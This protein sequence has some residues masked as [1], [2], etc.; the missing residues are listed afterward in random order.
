[1]LNIKSFLIKIMEY[2]NKKILEE[3]KKN[4]IKKLFN[5]VSQKYDLMN[6]IMSFGLHR[7]WKRDLIKLVIRERANI[8][9][10]LA[11][12]T[13]DISNSLARVLNNSLV[14]LYDLSFEMINY[15]K[16]KKIIIEIMYYLLMGV[17][18]N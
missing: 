10:D 13:G 7:I 14:V 12:G 11:G 17:Q 6:D 2:N 3:N 16:N 5:D 9:L 15:G 18:I 4:I 8:I 1:M